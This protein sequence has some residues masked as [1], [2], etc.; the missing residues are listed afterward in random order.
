[1]PPRVDATTGTRD[2]RSELWP[3]ELHYVTTVTT[4]VLGWDPRSASPTPPE[5]RRVLS[6]QRGH[7]GTSLLL[8]AKH[9]CQGTKTKATALHFVQMRVRTWETLRRRRRPPPALPSHEAVD[10]PGGE[11]EQD[12]RRDGDAYAHR[13]A[14]A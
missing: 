12:H 14:V 2:T 3:V 5:S 10:E 13:G 6:H 8:I 7:D 9:A 1:M 11:A 4:L